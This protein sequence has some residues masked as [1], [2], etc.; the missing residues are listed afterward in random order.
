MATPEVDGKTIIDK[1]YTVPLPRRGEA[2][3]S[4]GSAR[5]IL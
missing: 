3:R 1:R 2:R 5:P 4:L